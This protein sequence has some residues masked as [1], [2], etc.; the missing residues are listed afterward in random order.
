MPPTTPQNQTASPFA[1]LLKHYCRL[2]SRGRLLAGAFLLL[3]LAAAGSASAQGTITNCLTVICPPPIVTNYICGDVFTPQT[4]PIIISN[5]CPG[6]QFQVNCNPA[7]GTS[8][9][10]M[11]EN[12]W[13]WQS[14]VLRCGEQRRGPQRTN[15]TPKPLHIQWPAGRSFSAKTNKAMPAIQAKFMT[16]PMKRSNISNQQQ[17]TQTAP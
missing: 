17:P 4:Y 7:L 13:R 8:F 11:G 2:A 12:P 16:P 3:L 10:Y 6:L 9:A 5:S 14:R 1:S 15:R